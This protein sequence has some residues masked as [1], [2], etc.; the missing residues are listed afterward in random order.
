MP[1]TEHG[2][3]PPRRPGRPVK[4]PEHLDECLDVLIRRTN[5]WIHF[6][7]ELWYQT[8]EPES[9]EFL[10][11]PKLPRPAKE[12]RLP[13]LYDEAIAAA[14]QAGIAARTLEEK[15]KAG[16]KKI[17]KIS[18]SPAPQ[19]GKPPAAKARRS[20]NQPAAKGRST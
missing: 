7:E 8:A 20:G 6:C 2:Y 10:E 4:K 18:K 13:A 9:F 11:W 15:L 12:S 19:P 16:K 1:Y 3:E 14:Q 5:A 17:Q